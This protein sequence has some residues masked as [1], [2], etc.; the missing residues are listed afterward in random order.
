MNET[1]CE[2]I[3]IEKLKETTEKENNKDARLL[4]DLYFHSH[5]C[6]DCGGV[7]IFPQRYCDWNKIDF[8]LCK[9]CLHKKH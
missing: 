7:G 9:T 2:A 4:S 6:N 5:K 3:R 8:Y 1:E